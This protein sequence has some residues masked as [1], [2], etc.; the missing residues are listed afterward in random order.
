MASFE[1]MPQVRDPEAGFILNANSAVVPRKFSPSLGSDWGEPFRARR[2]QDFM[3]E[4]GPHTLD[5]SARMQAD[6]LS[7]AAKDLLPALLAVTPA[8]PQAKEAL[9][10]LQN[11]DGVMDKDRAEPLIFEAWL[12]EMHRLLLAAK[13]G[14]PLGEKGP[15]A[16]AAME[17]IL[18]NRAGEW[19]GKDDADCAKLKAEALNQ[20]LAMVSKRQG[21]DMNNW[22]WGR[23]NVAL[24]RH[25]FYSR[26][27]LST[28]CPISA[29]RA[30]ATSIRST[31]EAAPITMPIILLPAPTARAIAASTTLRIRTPRGSSSPRANR[32]ISSRA[33]MET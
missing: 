11:W 28:A 23:E 13:T 14:D 1:Q 29:S 30:A 31:G 9:T 3:N 10:L 24:L 15:F 12:S 7:L 6:H 19:C 8:T 25:K 18:A 17:F 32:A 20:A 27:P 33:T 22:R 26:I 2:I 5:I 16:A 4:D 21:P